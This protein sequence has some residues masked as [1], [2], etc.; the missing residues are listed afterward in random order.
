MP[1]IVDTINQLPNLLPLKPASDMEITD[2]ELQLRLSFASEYRE[3]LLAF[4][5]IMA[6]GIELSGIAKSDHRS[7]VA[8]TKRE[9][10]RSP[11]IPHKMYV[12]EDTATDGVVIW[13]NTDGAIYRSTPTSP[14]TLIAESLVEYINSSGS[15][16][17]F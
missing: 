14:P 1:N 2:A 6:D 12:V 15:K 11:S 13:Q 8:L 9:R 4:G 17:Q 5:A 10:K 16:S 3:Y 7:V